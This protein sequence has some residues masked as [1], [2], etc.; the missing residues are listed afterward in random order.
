MRARHPGYEYES[1]EEFCV[2]APGPIPQEVWIPDWTPEHVIPG[3]AESV[4]KEI[5]GKKPKKEVKNKKKD[6]A[7]TRKK[8][9][10]VVKEDNVGQGRA[11]K[12]KKNKKTKPRKTTS[13]GTV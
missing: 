4:N 7:A 3:A 2:R 6:A 5:E 9:V 11:K 1:Y 8:P 13:K 12:E 10:K